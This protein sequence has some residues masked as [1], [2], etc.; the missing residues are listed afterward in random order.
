[1]NIHV[2]GIPGREEREE[3]AEEIFEVITAENF[4]KLITETKPQI[5]EAVNLPSSMNTKKSTQ[6]HIILKL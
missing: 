6:R 5:Q 4:S 3:G 2:T 1:M